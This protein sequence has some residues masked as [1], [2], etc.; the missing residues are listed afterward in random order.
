MR[1]QHV[2]LRNAKCPKKT[3]PAGHRSVPESWNTL[4]FNMLS[5]EGAMHKFRA[6]ARAGVRCVPKRD[7]SL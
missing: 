5:E 3:H 2:S 6:R 7:Y 1:N 4:L